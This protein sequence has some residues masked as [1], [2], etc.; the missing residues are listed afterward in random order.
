LT[1]VGTAAFTGVSTA[2]ATTGTSG[3]GGTAGGESG[4]G[5]IES[6]PTCTGESDGVLNFAS[7]LPE[8]GSLAFL[9]PPMTAAV[10]LAQ[11]DIN[12]A[13]GVLGVDVGLKTGDSGDTTT[14]IATRT[15]A[16]GLAAGADVFIGSA[17]SGVTSTFIDTLVEACKVEFSPANTS[18]LFTDYPDD[19]LYFRTAPPDKLQGRVDADLIISEGITDVVFMARQDPYGEGLMNSATE[20]FADAGGN[21]VDSFVYDPTASTFQNE[22]DRVISADPEALMLIGFEESAQILTGLFE[23]GFTVDAGK[24]FFFVDGNLGDAMGEQLPAGSLTGQMGTTPA[25]PGV[26]DEFKQELLGIDPELTEPFNYGPETYDSMIIT[27]LAAIAADSDNPALI[28]AHI[29]GITRDGEKCTT[30]ADCRALIEAGT[31]I[32]YDGPAG[33]M[34]FAA[35]GEP[36]EANYGIY[37]YDDSNTLGTIEPTYVYI[38]DEDAGI[39]PADTSGPPEPPAPAGSAAPA[40]SAAP[41]DTATATS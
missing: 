12:A 26:S 23:G 37:T 41:A 9:G 3:G 13:G 27:A 34:T 38:V 25:S 15:V 4:G 16:D 5:T 7:V 24:R 35:A 32:D 21:V 1:L 33:P 28:A 20:A 2:G 36:G 6:A 11:R 31:D 18:A 19:G 10:Q 14:D 29:N 39:S 22:V 40:E 30:F 8:T 17:S